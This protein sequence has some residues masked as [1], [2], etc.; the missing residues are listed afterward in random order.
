VA[1]GGRK[2]FVGVGEAMETRAGRLK[3]GRFK[4]RKVTAKAASASASTAPLTP[5]MS[6]QEILLPPHS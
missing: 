6:R 5:T 3:D 1:V 4:G 2:T